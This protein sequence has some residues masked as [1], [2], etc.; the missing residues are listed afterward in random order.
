MTSTSS[1][2]ASS[3]LHSKS[4]QY[5]AQSSRSREK[6]LI[7]CT[8]GLLSQSAL[9]ARCG[10]RGR[11]LVYGIDGSTTSMDMDN[12]LYIKQAAEEGPSADRPGEPCTLQ[13]TLWCLV[14][15]NVRQN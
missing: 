1:T 10:V 6:R 2:T 9:Q 8:S 12:Q 11:G 5:A 7:H 15:H 3:P 4:T 14:G 13:Y